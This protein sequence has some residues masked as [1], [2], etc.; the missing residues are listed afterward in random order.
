[1][2]KIVTL[3]CL[4][5]LIG[6]ASAPYETE[7]TTPKPPFYS[8]DLDYCKDWARPTEEEETRDNYASGNYG[9]IGILVA[10]QMGGREGNLHKRIDHCMKAKG[11]SVE[12]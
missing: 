6:C 1:M 5:L 10:T 4:S 2:R 7:L 12:E 8:Q 11:Y 3:A 9:L